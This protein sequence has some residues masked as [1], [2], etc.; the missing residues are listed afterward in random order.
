[1]TD[2]DFK[3]DIGN[4]PQQPAGQ[5][6]VKSSGDANGDRDLLNQILG[7]AQAAQAIQQIS[8]T[9]GVSK[10]AYVKETKLY[11]ALKGTKKP[12]GSDFFKGTWD[13][14]CSL[15]GISVDKAD[16]DIANLNAFGEEALES[17]SRIGI[18]YRDMQQ[19]RK[20][21]GDER[22]ALIEVAKSGDKDQLLDLAES[23]IVK[24]AKE[25]AELAAE[26]EQ[27][28]ASIENHETEYQKLHDK[29]ET[30]D[31]NYQRLTKAKQPGEGIYNARTVE[32]RHEASAL[33][34]ASRINVD[35][36]DVIY[37]EVINDHE[38]TVQER[39]LQLHAIAIAAGGLLARAE[40]LYVRIKDDL[41]DLLPIKANADYILKDDEKAR[42]QD[43]VTMIDINFTRAQKKR[44]IERS[45]ERPGPGRKKGSTNKK[46]GEDV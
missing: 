35:A 44:D 16:H 42:L 33:E 24:H 21:P 25:K 38:T 46:G 31:R 34:Y 28:R 9:L 17:M 29:H 10:L 2:I 5:A 23:L 12:N 11:K 45:A 39:E 43:S 36:L 4:E 1:M 26:G 30:L 27:L 40:L 20:L 32:V 22:A 8:R 19:Y 6:L 18:G 41:G 3:L 14:F 15:Q 7:Q 37:G 13:E